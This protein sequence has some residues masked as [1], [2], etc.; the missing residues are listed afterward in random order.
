MAV[1]LAASPGTAFESAT[2]GA[3]QA[4]NL[5]Q[6]NVGAMA[7]GTSNRYELRVR[8]DGRQGKGVILK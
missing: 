8:V 2:G 1:A 5:V 6:W 7:A 4:G 3:T